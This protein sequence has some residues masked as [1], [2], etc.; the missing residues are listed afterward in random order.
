MSW[1]A[2]RIATVA[3]AV[4]LPGLQAQAQPIPMSPELKAFLTRPEE[5]Q[6]FGGM[7]GQIWRSTVENCPS[8]GVRGMNVVISVP[9]KFDQAG[10][11][12]SGEWR[13]T[14]QFEGCGKARTLTVLYLFGPD[15]RMMRAGLLPG[16]TITD[17]R[18]QKDAL[19][20]AAMG[21]A[22]I[23]P[24]DCKDIK[25]TDTKFMS[26][27]GATPPTAA[28]IGKRPWAEEW[29][30]RACGVTGVVTLNFSPNATGTQISSEVNKTRRVDP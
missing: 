8:P 11:P 5:Q 13:V 18:L 14:A 30:V 25:Y 9:P 20:Y 4:L 2:V 19:L 23:A 16:T 10:L 17:L 1:L 21:M 27:G 6:A 15:S 26:F 28:E 7:M 12:K 24:K 3:V 22:K 29:T